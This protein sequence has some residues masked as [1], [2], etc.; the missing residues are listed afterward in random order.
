M[1]KKIKYILIPLVTLAIL[2]APISPV[3]EGEKMAKVEVN[4]ALAVPS[5]KFSTP[6]YFYN[7]ETKTATIQI[8]ITPEGSVKYEND[9]IYFLLFKPATKDGQPDG[10]QIGQRSAQGEINIGE[11]NNSQVAKGTFTGIEIDTQYYYYVTISDSDDPYSEPYSELLKI[12]TDTENKVPITSGHFSFTKNGDGKVT[13]ASSVDR[14][15]NQA[16]FDFQCDIT[17]FSISGCFAQLLVIIWEV[18]ALIAKLAAGFLDFFVYYSTD[19]S[20]YTSSFVTKGWGVVRDISNIFFIL[21]LLYIAIKTILSLNTTDNKKLISYIVVIALLINFSLFFTQIIIDSS[22]IL[23]KVFYN[24]IT[25]V[26]SNGSVMDPGD[27]GEKSISVGLV[28][29][30]NPQKLVNQEFY[31]QSRGTFMFLTLLSIAITLYAAWI[32]FTVALLF[33]GRVI[34]LWLAMIFSPV[35]FA[36]YTVPFD[37][38]GFGHKQWWDELLKNAFLAPI[39]IFFLYLIIMFLDVG[40]KLTYGDVVDTS[41]GAGIMKSAMQVVIPFVMLFILLMKAKE[42]AVKFSGEMGAA[43]LKAGA[44]IGGAAVGVAAGGLAVAGRATIGRAG[45]ALANS[46]RFKK[47]ESE[48]KFGAA[49]IRNIGKASAKGSMDVRG[50]K[51][52]GKDLASTGLKVNTFG[53]TQ[54]GGFEKIRADKTEKRTKRAEELKV[55]KDSKENKKKMKI[56]SAIKLLQNEAAQSLQAIDKKEEIAKA[57]LSDL[58]LQNRGSDDAEFQ[59][60]SKDLSDAKEERKAIKEGKEIPVPVLDNNGNQVMEKVTLKKMKTETTYAKIPGTNTDDLTKPLSTKMVETGETEEVV[61]PKMTSKRYTID[62]EVVSKDK[63]GNPIVENGRE[64]MVIEKRSIA[65]LEK[66]DLKEVTNKITKQDNDRLEKYS[67]HIGSKLNKTLNMISSLGQHSSHGADEASYKILMGV[68]V[69]NS[70]KH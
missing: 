45:N 15:N 23:A 24:N 44:M 55:G 32:F 33:V 29:K 14:E 61:Q 3:F 70:A 57:A 17:S 60:H 13:V 35:A 62:V 58:K 8:T 46:E 38:P 2:L 16:A 68:K 4:R 64:K 7:A 37:I 1:L 40:M 54:E 66:I 47:W 9:E 69:E 11:G 49:T 51:I 26:D 34:S 27:G 53:K 31:N 43:I 56:E 63:N 10:N 48:G 19:S 50:M 67:K 22:N 30:F 18:T 20:S 39:F 21:A 59:K 36:S 5:T 12:E 65:D 6:K 28:E 42:M 25:S 52:A 41:T